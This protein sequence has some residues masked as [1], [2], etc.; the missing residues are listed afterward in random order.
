MSYHPFVET[1][2]WVNAEHLAEV[3]NRDDVEGERLKEIDCII[4]GLS[5]LVDRLGDLDGEGTEPDRDGM[6]Y[7]R[8]PWGIVERYA[9]GD[10]VKTRPWPSV[11]A[12]LVRW[13]ESYEAKL[14]KIHLQS[15]AFLRVTTSHQAQTPGVSMSCGFKGSKKLPCVGC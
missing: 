2:L 14:R 5:R 1:A 12:G 15:K 10:F 9:R 6:I 13:E 8:G 7:A 4:L 3:F 11:R